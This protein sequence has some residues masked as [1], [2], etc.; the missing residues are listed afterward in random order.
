MDRQRHIN[1]SSLSITKCTCFY[2][3]DMP[4]TGVVANHADS[5]SMALVCGRVS[6][7]DLGDSLFLFTDSGDSLF[8]LKVHIPFDA[9]NHAIVETARNS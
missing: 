8:L 3:T 4:K 7:P 1:L 5:G 6:Y 9:Q 2:I